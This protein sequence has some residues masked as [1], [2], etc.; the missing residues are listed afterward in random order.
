VPED[1]IKIFYSY[2]RKDL[3]MRN[4]LEDHLSTLR[5]A[6]KISTWHDLQLEAGTEWEPAILNKLDTA[7]IILLLISSNFIASNYCYG[8][9][10]KR[11][12]ARH[13]D[14]TARVI[15]I[16]LRPCDWNHA[17][18]PFSRLNV[19]PT[20]AQPITKWADPED[21]LA[22]VAQRIREVVDQLR[23][24]K[25]ARRPL[26]EQPQ[27]QLLPIQNKLQQ[28]AKNESLNVERLP[29]QSALPTDHS[30]CQS[31]LPTSKTS[32][33]GQSNPNQQRQAFKNPYEDKLNHYQLQY[34][35]AIQRKHP[36]S[37]RDRH[38]LESLRQVLGLNAD[39]VLKVEKG[40]E[41]DHQPVNSSNASLVL[42]SAKQNILDARAQFSM[43]N[44]QSSTNL[45][46]GIARR[47][48]QSSINLAEEVA[49]RLK[50]EMD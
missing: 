23:N 50:G 11:A 31:Q 21:A 25:L 1:A 13:D 6:G 8:T 41:L 37:E 26:G 20:H 28:Q 32:S 44:E 14:G 38:A 7:D 48:K 45:V 15:P 39:D 34:L 24:E 22:I 49:R 33:G 43:G 46:D 36:I 42:P 47:L 18:V 3:D 16:I 27:Q 17:D 30:L 29:F 12:I 19:L 4:A 40:I 2:S 35:E 5:V 10:L 9:E